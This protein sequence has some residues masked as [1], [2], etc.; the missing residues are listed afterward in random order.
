[1]AGCPGGLWFHDGSK[2]ALHSHTLYIETSIHAHQLS[3]DS[4][5]AIKAAPH[6]E[7][8]VGW[9]WCSIRAWFYLVNPRCETQYSF[10]MICQQI[11]DVNMSQQSIQFYTS[12]F[13]RCGSAAVCAWIK[14]PTW[15]SCSESGLLE[16]SEQT[17]RSIRWIL[18]SYY[19]R[20]ETSVVCKKQKTKNLKP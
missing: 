13:S 2:T 15:E 1:M 11:T 18:Q 7:M 3:P 6:A 12:S 10:W 20:R 5:W 4:Q 9:N 16:P 19:W 14:P 17:R 8:H